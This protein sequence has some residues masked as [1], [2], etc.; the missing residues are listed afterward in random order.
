[1]LIS[2]LL[3]R[4]LVPS[5]DYE[6]YREVKNQILPS[7]QNESMSSDEWRHV[8]ELQTSEKNNERKRDQINSGA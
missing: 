6:W 2:N 7:I 3:G 1:M 5:N 4:D 8:G